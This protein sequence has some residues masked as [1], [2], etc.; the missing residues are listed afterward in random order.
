MTGDAFPGAPAA[1][2]PALCLDLT[3]YAR[4]VFGSGEPE[5]FDTP[6]LMAQLR[7]AQ[8]SLR[9]DWVLLPLLDWAAAWWP[10]RRPGADA[11]RNP[12]RVLKTR[13]EDPALR[14]ALVDVL[15]ALHGVIGRAGL[16]LHLGSGAQWL[17]W[18]GDDDADADDAEEALV[19]LAALLHSLAGSGIAAVVV[20]Q[21]GEQPEDLDEHFAALTNAAHHHGWPCA[22]C[23]AEHSHAPAGFDALACRTPAAG[24][25]LWH[26]ETEWTDTPASPAAP[27]IVARVPGDVTPDAVLSR[28]AHWR[29]A[30]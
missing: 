26:A 19:Y 4:Q 24:Q 11:G 22:L 29:D 10:A 13:L 18:A 17:A 6:T 23:A 5:W 27:F 3:A 21:T 30:R 28:I 12:L 9:A 20:E 15:R 25:G 14:A 2:G 16:A 1:G 8:Q 7:Q